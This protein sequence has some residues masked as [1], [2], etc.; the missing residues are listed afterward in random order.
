MSFIFGGNTGLTYDDLKRKRQI[1]EALSKPSAQAPQTAG[2]GLAAIGKA[3]ASRILEKKNAGL[4]SELSGLPEGDPRR[5]G[6]TDD[7]LQALMGGGGGGGA[8]QPPQMAQPPMPMGQQPPQQPPQ[9]LHP[10]F[11]QYD[12]QSQQQML[13]NPG[14]MQPPP[15]DFDPYELH[16]GDG[17]TRLEGG[18][19]Q[20]YLQGGDISAISKR[21]GNDTAA[22]DIKHALMSFMEGLDDYQRIYRDGGGAMMPGPQ[23]DRLGVQRTALQMQMKTLYE[24][25]ALQGPDMALL[26][27]MMAFDPTAVGANVADML[28]LANMDDRFDTN[29]GQ[30][31]DIMMDMAAP[32]LREYG[33]S[34]DEV[35]RLRRPTEGPSL[36]ELSDDDLLKLLE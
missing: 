6:A 23:K 36:E 15:N 1:A 9:Q 8:A 34:A 13:N 19:G 20:D 14:A 11:D 4:A 31:R 24:L 30:L 32:K 3:L 33:I 12:P 16:F 10:Q 26:E 17:D 29:I 22:L 35:S 21:A 5:G 2:E 28:G 7:I 18:S 27:R 25:G